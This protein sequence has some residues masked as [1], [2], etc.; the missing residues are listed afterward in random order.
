M[1]GCYCATKKNGSIW[2][3]KTACATWMG[4]RPQLF[5]LTNYGSYNP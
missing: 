4:N 2:G 1:S 3:I 5:K